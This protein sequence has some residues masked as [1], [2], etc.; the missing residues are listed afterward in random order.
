MDMVRCAYRALAICARAALWCVGLF[1]RRV[2]V[3]LVV[4]L[5]VCLFV[6][7]LLLVFGYLDS[8]G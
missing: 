3:V 8:G 1:C 2:C 4:F 6:L 5:F 7:L